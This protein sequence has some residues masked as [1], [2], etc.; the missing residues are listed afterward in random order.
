MVR[1]SKEDCVAE[2]QLRRLRSLR[3]LALGHEDCAS[4][5]KVD[6]RVDGSLCYAM[7]SV[8]ARPHDKAAHTAMIAGYL[9]SIDHADEGTGDY[10]VAYADQVKNDYETLGKAVRKDDSKPT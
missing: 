8:L 10:A 7:R 5:G 4:G 9:G 3:V 1:N 6:V 2:L